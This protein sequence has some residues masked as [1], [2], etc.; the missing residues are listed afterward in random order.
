MSSENIPCEIL[1]TLW[2]QWKEKKKSKCLFA[3]LGP[4]LKTSNIKQILGINESS[5]TS[6]TAGSFHLNQH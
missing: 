6:G 4:G 1:L 5:G 2:S 3:N